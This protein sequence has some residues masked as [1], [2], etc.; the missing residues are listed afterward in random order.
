LREKQEPEE[1]EVHLLC[2]RVKAIIMGHSAPINRLSRD[3]DNACHYANWPGPTTPQFDLL[4]AWPPFEP[5]S[6]QI[7]E[8]F[9]RSYGRALFARPYSFLLLA[10]A[11]T[12]PVAA[13]ETLVMHASPGYERDPL[14][15][16]ICGLEGIFARYPEVLSIQA[17]EVLAS[18]MLKPQRRAGN[19]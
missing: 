1:N 9:V 8:L 2:E 18:F 16:V 11:A 7:V 15:S 17:R 3:I 19:E 14:R 4:C 5:V 10:L 13:A 6:A 12:G